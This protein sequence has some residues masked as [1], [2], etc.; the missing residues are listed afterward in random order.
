VRAD[1]S[2]RI[3]ST[4]STHNGFTTNQ[5]PVPQ[6]PPCGRGRFTGGGFQ[7]NDND[8]RVSRGFTLHCDAILSNNFEVNWGRRQQF[9]HR[10]EPDERRVLARR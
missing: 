9:P 5:D 8:L 10:Q 4:L 7:I 3:V 6:P 1:S 2:V